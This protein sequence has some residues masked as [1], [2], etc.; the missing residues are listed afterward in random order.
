MPSTAVP[1]VTTGTR[2]SRMETHRLVGER[3]V[4]REQAVHP[5]VQRSGVQ[6]AGPAATGGADRV[7]QQVVALLA[8]STSWAPST[9]AEKN[10]RDTHGA[11]TPMALVRPVVRA[12]ADGEGK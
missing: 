10:Q 9:T 3:H 7:Q 4:Q 11:I 2:R 12:A 5:L 8:L 6:A 1:T